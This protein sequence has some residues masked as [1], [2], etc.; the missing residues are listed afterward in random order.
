MGSSRGHVGVVVRSYCNHGLG[1]WGVCGVG[2]AQQED[3]LAPPDTHATGAAGVLRGSERRHTPCRTKRTRANKGGEAASR[4]PI[5]IADRHPPSATAGRNR[6]TD[7]GESPTR[8]PLPATASGNRDSY[9][10][11]HTQNTRSRTQS[12]QP[13]ISP[14]LPGSPLWATGSYRD[15]I[16]V[17]LGPS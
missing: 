11:P 15:H 12:I 16:R 2:C 3:G 13:I 4:L 17:L 14:P 1:A 10:T 7:R 8:R 5:E 9:G 6:D